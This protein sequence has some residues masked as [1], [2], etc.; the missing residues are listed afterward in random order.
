MKSVVLIGASR[1]GKSTFAKMLSKEL[2]S[3][4]IISGDIVRLAY[5]DEIYKNKNV[6][7]S[8]MK[9]IPEYKRFLKSYFDYTIK[10]GDSIYTILDTV[11]FKP[12]DYKLFENSLI[13]VFGHPKLTKED[14][15]HNWR[16]HTGSNDWTSHK[17]D[18]ELLNKAKRTIA[19]SK[20]FLRECKKYHL[21][22]V[23]TS[24]NRDKVLKEL[25][26]WTKNK[27]ERDSKCLN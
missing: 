8:L 3:C 27:L 7:S 23:D 14:C 13:I 6:K 20:H 26:Q 25:L 21:K 19:D 18:E 5:R 1:A 22:F 10:Y 12:S 24:F 16:T 17:T 2:K 4:Q 15:L 11:D 9:E